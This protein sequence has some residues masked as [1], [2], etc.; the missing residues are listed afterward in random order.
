MRAQTTQLMKIPP[1]P[2]IAKTEGNQNL[3]FKV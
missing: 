3:T 2:Q 1:S